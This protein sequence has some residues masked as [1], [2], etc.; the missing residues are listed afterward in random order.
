M[1]TAEPARIHLL[2]AK[3]APFVI[4]IR[5]K[6][7]KRFHVIRWNTKSDNLEHGSWFHGKLY[8]YRCDVSFDGQWMVYLAMGA[9]GNTWNGVCQPPFLRS[10]VTGPNMGAWFGGGYWRDRQTL[11]LNQ[12]QPAKGSVPFQLGE[13][14]AEFGGEDLSVLYPR[15]KRDGWQRRG[16]DFG[17][18]QEVTNASKYSVE[19]VGD[20]GWKNKPSRKHPTLVVRYVGYLTHGYTFRFSLDDFPELLDDHVDSA[21]WDSLG[22]L[23]YARQGILHKYSLSDLKSGR[24]GTVVDLEPLLPPRS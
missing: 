20:D 15:W 19:C 8:P 2:P 23:L 4:V 9:S 16:D 6:P 21:C 5:R 13:L 14:R 12:W 17:T 7:S 22:N 10:V 11:L 1:K 18:N 24:P 3:T